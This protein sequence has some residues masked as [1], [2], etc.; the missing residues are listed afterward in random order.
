[1]PARYQAWVDHLNSVIETAPLAARLDVPL[2]RRADSEPT[3]PSHQ[4][5]TT[6]QQQLVA[7]R[8]SVGVTSKTT[9]SPGQST[10]GGAKIA[11]GATLGVGASTNS[12]SSAVGIAGV[13][14]GMK[15]LHHNQVWDKNTQSRAASFGYVL[16][17]LPRVWHPKDPAT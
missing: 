3:I 8:T 4:S 12:S 17:Y 16:S 6:Q 10:G 14:P 13:I 15:S 7:G 5:A 11:S 2:L 9:Q 1:M